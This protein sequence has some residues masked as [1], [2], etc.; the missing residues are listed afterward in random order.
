MEDAHFRIFE[1]CR[2]FMFRQRSCC[3]KGEEY[4]N[5]NYHWHDHHLCGDHDGHW[6]LHRTADSLRQ[7]FC[8]GR[9][10]RRL[11]AHRIRLRHILF[12]RCSLH[13]LCRTVRLDIRRFC[14]MGRHRQRP[15]GQSAGMDRP[16]TAHPHHDAVAGRKDHAGILRKALELQRTE[17]RSRCDRLYLSDSLYRI[18]VQRSVPS[19]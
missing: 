7:R 14:R 10:Q 18:G 12:F 11:M 8:P 3:H 19:V 13:R 2:K 6:R 1:R 9:S 4:D 15:A 5:R 16:G 17:S